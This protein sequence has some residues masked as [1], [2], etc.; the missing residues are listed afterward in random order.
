MPPP[1]TLRPGD[2]FTIRILPTAPRPDGKQISCH[3]HGS[4]P[5]GDAFPLWTSVKPRPQG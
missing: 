1:D 3:L 4:K 5:G 2:T